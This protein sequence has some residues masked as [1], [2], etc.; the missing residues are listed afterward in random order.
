L[1]TDPTPG[2]SLVTRRA[3]VDIIRTATLG[4]YGVTGFAAGLRDRL[5]AL[6]G[7]RHPGIRV[8]L[9]DP[10][11]IELRLTVAFGLPVAEVARQVDSAV[12]YAIRV[13]L[14]RE[15]GRL[16]IHVG[17]LRYQ[18]GGL[19]PTAGVVAAAPGAEVLSS[20]APDPDPEPAAA[21]AGPAG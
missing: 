2:R 10:L 19:P 16:T 17:G 9:S 8:E 12:R 4:S 5:L 11:E 20:T 6:V 21:D 3:V 7:I 1:P 15:I 14:G 18:P 13:G